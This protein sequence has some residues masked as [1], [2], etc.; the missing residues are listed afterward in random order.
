MLHQYFDRS[1]GIAGDRG[2]LDLAVFA[3]FIATGIRHP[4]RKP[5]IPVSQQD[6]E[7]PINAVIW[8]LPMA[9]LPERPSLAALAISIWCCGRPTNYCSFSSLTKNSQWTEMHWQK[10]QR[11]IT[12]GRTMTHLNLWPAPSKHLGK[13]SPS[14]GRLLRVLCKITPRRLGGNR[15]GGKADHVAPVT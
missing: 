1:I 12:T 4:N 8:S 9:R 6:P 3:Q 14:S 13:Y 5:A 2:I 7:A 10:R 15:V 11:R